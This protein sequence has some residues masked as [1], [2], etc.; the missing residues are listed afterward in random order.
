MSLPRSLYAASLSAWWCCPECDTAKAICPGCAEPLP[1]KRPA[2]HPPAL[3]LH[4]DFKC[5]DPYC[6]A[7]L[8]LTV[9][10]YR[11]NPTGDAPAHRSPLSDPLPVAERPRPNIRPRVPSPPQAAATDPHHHPRSRRSGGPPGRLPPDLPGRSHP[12]AE[13]TRTTPEAGPLP[14]RGTP[15]PPGCLG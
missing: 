4:W 10:G 13:A 1:I 9:C 11:P 7:A 5:P 12:Q 15:L 14:G 8:A 6:G 2:N 3:P